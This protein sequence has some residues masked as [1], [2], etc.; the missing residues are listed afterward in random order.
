MIIITEFRR[1]KILSGKTNVSSHRHTLPPTPQVH[2][3]YTNYKPN[4]HQQEPTVDKNDSMKGENV[5]GL[6]WGHKWSKTQ[7]NILM[8]YKPL[9]GT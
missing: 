5:T 2:I 7:K 4:F 1:H 8:Q 3:L 9:S 6:F